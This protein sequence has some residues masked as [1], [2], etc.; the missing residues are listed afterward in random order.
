MPE[1]SILDLSVRELLGAVAARTSA[2]GGG[3]VAAVAT[4]LA[5]ALTGMAARFALPDG[6]VGAGEPGADGRRSVVGE[7]D[8]LRARAA[9][10][11]D[12]DATAYAAFLAALRLPRDD[13]GR[14]CAVESARD[15]AAAVP[16]EIA[17]LAAAVSDLAV[18]LV[19]GGNPNLRGDAV[20]AVL[21]AGAA[22]RTAAEL[23]AVN[24]GA[25]PRT[26]RARAYAA[27]AQ[28]RADRISPTTVPA[29]VAENAE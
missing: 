4:A 26:D 11:A 17:A 3:A 13:P 10:L 1:A 18:P 20:A 28:D 5:A 23:V 7:A 24:V 19:D 15:G 29:P 6:D 22:A 8:G 16:G 12:A 2:P 14:A 25:D 27:A 9:V 21:L